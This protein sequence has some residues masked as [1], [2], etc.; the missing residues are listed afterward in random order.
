[1]R[2]ALPPHYFNSRP[3][4]GGRH[5]KAAGNIRSIAFQF[6]PPRGGDLSRMRS[7]VSIEFQFTPPR[8]GDGRLTWRGCR[9]IYFNS[10]PREGAT[11]GGCGAP[12]GR[13]DFNSRPREGAT[14]A[15]NKYIAEH[16]FQFTPPR[17]GDTFI[18]RCTTT[19]QY[20]NSRPREG[21][22]FAATSQ[23]MDYIISIHAPARGRQK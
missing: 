6:S 18:A 5:N 3:P 23:I 14:R 12:Q 11:P 2:G 16:I 21:A 8:G 13:Q 4:Q 7:R 22:T 10:R 19:Q 20:F 9:V 15:N 1:M 17:G